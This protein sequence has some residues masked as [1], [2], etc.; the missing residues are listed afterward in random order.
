MK[1][2]TNTFAI[3][4]ELGFISVCYFIVPPEP[5]IANTKEQQ[6]EFLMS[7]ACC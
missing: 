2:A 1:I 5:S 3:E 4:W 6:K 7:L